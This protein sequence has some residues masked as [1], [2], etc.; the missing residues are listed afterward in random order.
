MKIDAN[1]WKHQQPLVS[2][3]LKIEFQMLKIRFPGKTQQLNGNQNVRP[4]EVIHL[5]IPYLI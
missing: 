3:G 2:A 1:Y 4:D 5:D